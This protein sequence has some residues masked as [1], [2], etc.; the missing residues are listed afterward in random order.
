MIDCGGIFAV[1]RNAGCGMIGDTLVVI[2]KFA[3]D[4]FFDWLNSSL[5]IEAAAAPSRKAAAAAR[6]AS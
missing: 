4:S 1:I 3:G 6:A 5:F 2:K